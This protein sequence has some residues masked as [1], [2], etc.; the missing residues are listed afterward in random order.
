M[1]P[2]RARFPVFDPINPFKSQK[3]I[4]TVI[5]EWWTGAQD[6]SPNSQAKYDVP[7]P[8]VLGN[9]FLSY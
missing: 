3:A 2:S 6:P 1:I 8:I 7:L 9:L 4:A 5:S